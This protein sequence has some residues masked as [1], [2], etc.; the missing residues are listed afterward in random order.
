MVFLGLY[1]LALGI[2]SL[3]EVMHP[4]LKKRRSKKA[5]MGIR[6]ISVNL[7]Q[8]PDRH[9]QGARNISVPDVSPELLGTMALGVSTSGTQDIIA[10]PQNSLVTEIPSIPLSPSSIHSLLL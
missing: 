9:L 1:V 8:S 2:T 10:Q 4:K 5:S 3:V 7:Q 6:N